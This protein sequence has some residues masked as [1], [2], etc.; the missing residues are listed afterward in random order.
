[1]TYGRISPQDDTALLKYWYSYRGPIYI[2][3]SSGDPFI[4][5]D[6]LSVEILGS[7]YRRQ[8]LK[9]TL[10][11]GSAEAV[12]RNAEDLSWTVGPM[13]SVS[14]LVGWDA[15]FNGNPR[16]YTPISS[17]PVDYPAGGTHKHPAFEL[18]IGLDS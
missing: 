9:L 18:F 17:G 1:M 5:N 10:V 11:T 16:F 4:V 15:A 8:L 3:L 6:P 12:L 7:S 2:G 13:T 14:G